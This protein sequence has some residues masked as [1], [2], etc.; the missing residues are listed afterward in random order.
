MCH[1]VES[2]IRYGIHHNK[3]EKDIEFWDSARLLIKAHK[4]KRL[5]QL[6]EEATHGI[7]RAADMDNMGN[8][9]ELLLKHHR[10]LL[11]SGCGKR[12]YNLYIDEL[13][14]NK[15]QLHHIQE[16]DHTDHHHT[17]TEVSHVVRCMSWDK[18]MKNIV[19]EL[20]KKAPGLEKP[21]GDA[22][23]GDEESKE[24]DKSE[25][26]MGHDEMD[27]ADYNYYA[28]HIMNNEGTKSA[29]APRETELIL[30]SLAEQF[31]FARKDVERQLHEIKENRGWN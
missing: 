9:N 4:K 28:K 27:N 25:Y 16:L 30:L 1:S 31:L 15:D 8:T 7:L 19:P 11:L 14:Y 20:K 2:C 22:A 17:N 23:L 6:Q 12:L 10:K 3:T 13:R 24:N 18:F 5:E 26:G 29:T 21:S